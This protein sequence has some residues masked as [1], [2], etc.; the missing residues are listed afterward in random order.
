MIAAAHV[1]SISRS[2]PLDVDDEEEEHVSVNKE[3]VVN[4][5]EYEC[6][7]EEEEGSDFTPESATLLNRRKH[8]GHSLETTHKQAKTARTKKKVVAPV[9]GGGWNAASNLRVWL[10]LPPMVYYLLVAVLLVKTMLFG[11]NGQSLLADTVNIYTDNALC[12][13]STLYIYY[14]YL[15]KVWY[16]SK[17]HVSFLFEFI[18]LS[19]LRFRSCEGRTVLIG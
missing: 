9:S 1:L 2:I 14:F 3:V 5:L 8:S 7:E 13:N 16:F 11:V 19:M 18:Y 12:I 4:G 6:S 10:L 17:V 15:H